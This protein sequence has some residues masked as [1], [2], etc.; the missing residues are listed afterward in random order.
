M[1]AVESRDA[2]GFAI[3]ADSG[4]D[5]YEIHGEDQMKRLNES[6]AGGSA[7]FLL[8]S[9]RYR[10]TDEKVSVFVS[11]FDWDGAGSLDADSQWTRDRAVFNAM[12]YKD[13]FVSGKRLHVVTEPVTPLWNVIGSLTSEEIG[14]GLY[15]TLVG[16]PFL[17]EKEANADQKWLLGRLEY[18]SPSTNVTQDV[19]RSIAEATPAAYIP[20]EDLVNDQDSTDPNARDVFQLGVLINQCIKYTAQSAGGP[21]LNWS[22]LEEL[23]AGL[24]SPSPAERP[25]ITKILHNSFFSDSPLIFAVEVFLKNV[26]V[27]GKEQKEAGFRWYA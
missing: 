4:I 8:Y 13:S 15:N 6:P 11:T 7:L 3:A 2:S 19:V 5:D 9:A 10:L 20:P 18:L 27:F 12:Q 17:L 16:D 24:K 25:S 26:R 22:T 21:Y 1:G 23:V 14:M